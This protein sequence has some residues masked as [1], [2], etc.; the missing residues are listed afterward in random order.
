MPLSPFLERRLLSPVTSSPLPL[1]GAPLTSNT[2]LDRSRALALAPQ[3]AR[4]GL[5]LPRRWLAAG[6]L[7]LTGVAG[8]AYWAGRSATPVD[9]SGPSATTAGNLPAPLYSPTPPTAGATA[10]PNTT[11][12]P[13]MPTTAAAGTGGHGSAAAMPG[14]TPTAQA[15]PM[16]TA[17]ACKQCGV[18]E[19]VQA[20]QH[21]APTSGVGA[22]AGGVL[23]GM[24]GNQMGKG[25]GRTAMTVLGAVG[26]GMAG[27]EVEKRRNGSTTYRVQVRTDAGTLRT[28]EQRTA[29]PVG[30]RVRIDG[31]TLHALAP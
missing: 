24:L 5:A 30:Q 21:T 29:P 27:N 31:H 12:S 25:N 26:G 28:L 14:A 18:V 17:P 19:S 4:P 13:P 23:G 20:V 6:L 22:L 11:T 7:A 3:H 16:A 8:A 2:A 15:A 1:A 10:A 9:L